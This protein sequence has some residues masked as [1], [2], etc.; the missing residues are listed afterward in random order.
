M[1]CVGVESEDMLY[2]LRASNWDEIE[3]GGEECAKYLK[4]LE[5]LVREVEEASLEFSDRDKERL[6]DLVCRISAL[7]SSRSSS[8]PQDLK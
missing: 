1:R 3:S 6:K 5:N 2:A 8:D 7:C 4:S